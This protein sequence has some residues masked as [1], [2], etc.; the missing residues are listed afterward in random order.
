MCAQT[1]HKTRTQKKKR[2]LQSTDTRL[3]QE[4]ETQSESPEKVTPRVLER[5]VDQLFEDFQKLADTLD[6]PRIDVTTPL[7]MDLVA[8]DVSGVQML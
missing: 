7:P 3:D 4:F 8:G 6:L 1:N 2:M 5:Q